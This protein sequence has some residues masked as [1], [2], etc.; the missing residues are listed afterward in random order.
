MTAIASPSAVLPGV[1]SPRAWTVAVGAALANGVAFGTLYTFG[2]F[3]KEIAAEF[4]SGL[5]PT[6]TVFG[7][8]MFLFFGTGAVSGP[9]SD[10]LGARP[11]L[12]VGGTMFCGGLLLTSQA[13]EIWHAY[14]AYGIGA[15]LGGG[16]FSAP[17]F[18]VVASW[19]RRHIASAQGVA[20]TGPG[21]GT[22]ILLP[23][24]E[25]L[26]E[27]Y[28]WRTSYQILAAVCAVGFVIAWMLMKKSPTEAPKQAAAHRRAVVGTRQ[29]KIMAAGGLLMS[30]ALMPAFILVVP[31]AQDDGF[32]SSRAALIPAIIGTSS[33]LGRLVLTGLAGRIGPV[34]MF[35][36]CLIAQP[37]GYGVWL[38]F[39]DSYTGLI[40][41]AVLLGISYGGFVALVGAVAA[42]LFGVVGI[43]SIMGLLYFASGVGSGIGPPLTG[44]LS[45]ATEGQFVPQITVLVTATAAALV[46]LLLKPD[47]IQL[48]PA[49]EPSRL[50]IDL[51]LLTH[52]RL[53]PAI[54]L[55]DQIAATP[56]T[57]PMRHPAP[58]TTGAVPVGVVAAKPAPAARA[59]DDVLGPAA[60]LNEGGGPV[61]MAPPPP[62]TSPQWDAT[63]AAWICWEPVRAQWMRH[64]VGTDQW[65]VIG[66]PPTADGIPRVT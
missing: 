26:I 9:W 32:S 4:D 14:V 59:S 6:A 1:D 3:I 62:P 34:R 54:D 41:F 51:D 8:T 48:E 45:D 38:A 28:G 35:Q 31:F 44:F 50:V 27:N 5:G 64:D 21:L 43:G 22:L 16:I 65:V 53:P 20:A 63:W 30:A 61:E 15:G 2:V 24:S 18:A 39:G 11:L 49:A 42:H 40:V 66:A 60:Q 46:L 37:V 47:P 52:R 33:I 29:F 57:L 56:A 36:I 58:R 13:T 19:F 17:L 12:L 7:I 55:R 10:R 25:R 23:V